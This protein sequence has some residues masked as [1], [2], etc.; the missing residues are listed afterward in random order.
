MEKFSCEKFIK[1]QQEGRLTC[2]TYVSDVFD[3]SKFFFLSDFNV[4][5][6][7]KILIKIKKGTVYHMESYDI[8]LWPRTIS[9]AY[10]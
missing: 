8:H 4:F 1:Y 10:Y 3:Y 6:S 5:F 2:P 9:I 7:L